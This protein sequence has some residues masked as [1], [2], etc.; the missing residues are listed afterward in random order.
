LL[1]RG[2]GGPNRPVSFASRFTKLHHI[3]TTTTGGGSGSGGS[4][5]GGSDYGG[6]GGG[7]YGGFGGG[8]V[9]VPLAG[10]SPLAMLG[11]FNSPSTRDATEGNLLAVN[12]VQ[13]MFDYDTSRP[14]RGL[15]L[16]SVG[17]LS[18]PSTPVGLHRHAWRTPA[19]DRQRGVGSSGGGSGVSQATRRGVGVRLESSLGAQ[20]ESASPRPTSLTPLQSPASFG[21]PSSSLS[22]SFA[23]SGG[24]ATP[25][26]PL[27]GLQSA[28]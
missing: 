8:T 25:R 11:D 12:H 6:Y 3:G 28:V 4:G 27:G 15:Q 19:L 17:K 5:S 26:K 13:P 18:A 10:R 16:G 23:G 2:T 7:G 14:E 1:R 22:L 24:G 9:G 20:C 21:T